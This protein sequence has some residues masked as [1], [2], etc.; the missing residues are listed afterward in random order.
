MRFPQ[1]TQEQ[2]KEVAQKRGRPMNKWK[3]EEFEA[4]YPTNG[5]PTVWFEVVHYVGGEWG[6]IAHLEFPN[7]VDAQKACDAMNA[8]GI[9]YWFECAE[10]DAQLYTYDPTGKY[11]L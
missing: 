8:A 7:E 6:T 4:D 9:L 10:G 11:F 5:H 1:Y 3:V 2:L